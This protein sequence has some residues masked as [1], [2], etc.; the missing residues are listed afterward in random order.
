MQHVLIDRFNVFIRFIIGTSC[1]T[2]SKKTCWKQNV[3]FWYLYHPAFVIKYQSD[4]F[5]QTRLFIITQC[6]RRV[7]KLVF[8]HYTRSSNRSLATKNA[9]AA[10]CKR[11][12]FS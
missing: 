9:R 2:P 7:N 12:Y 1:K 3:Q 4:M 5:L 8:Y 6:H 10:L 11:N